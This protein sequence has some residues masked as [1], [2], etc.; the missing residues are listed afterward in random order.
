MRNWSLI[1]ARR[2]L[3]K[4]GTID[5]N[6]IGAAMNEEQP[7]PRIVWSEE[8]EEMF[9]EQHAAS[10]AMREVDEEIAARLREEP[11]S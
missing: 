9:A 3:R 5:V 11:C 1:S 2:S 10:E 8:D 6:R 7:H 4:T